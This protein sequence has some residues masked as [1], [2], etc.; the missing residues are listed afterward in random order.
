MLPLN[1]DS[2]F[3]TIQSYLNSKNEI[4]T[5]RNIAALNLQVQ[6]REISSLDT[7]IHYWSIVQH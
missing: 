7:K 5:I 6:D 4:L 3:K 2:E 1:L